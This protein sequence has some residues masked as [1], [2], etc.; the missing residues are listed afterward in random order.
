M[1]VTSLRP[2]L[3]ELIEDDIQQN[4]AAI[5]LAMAIKDP[6]VRGEYLDK[7]HKSIEKTQAIISK[8]KSVAI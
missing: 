2:R 8:I 5:K 6:V 4:N 7:I 3:I 1:Q